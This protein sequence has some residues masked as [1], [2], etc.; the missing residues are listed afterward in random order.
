M[1][2]EG[3]RVLTPVLP[4]G[5]RENEVVSHQRDLLDSYIADNAIDSFIAWYYTPMALSFSDDLL[6]EV[7][8]Y[9]CMDELSAFFAAPAGLIEQ[10][11]RLFERADAVF[12][13]GASLYG[14]KKGQHSNVHLFPSSIDRNHFAAAREHQADPDDQVAITH[15]RIGFFGVLD[16]RLDR[17]LLSQVAANH[18]EWQFVLIGPVVK[19]GPDELPRAHN[20]HYLGQKSYAELPR[21]LSNWDVAI[22]PFARNAATRFIS[23]TKTPEYLAAGKPVVSTPI[24]DVVNPYGELGLVRIGGNPLEFATAIEQCLHDADS[25]WIERVDNFLAKTS[26]DKT[27][28]G[29]WKEIQ[30]LIPRSAASSA[31]CT[32]EER[33]GTNV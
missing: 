30:R 24:H 16:E 4:E 22:L 11:Q 13:G 7:T 25:T 32:A 5:V 19:I 17:D 23:P 26:W 33:S 20:I 21:Y 10:E 1:S 2:P 6:P 31:T 15:P 29:M 8:I 27:F 14:A 18:P 28:Q 9:D 12:A 3:I